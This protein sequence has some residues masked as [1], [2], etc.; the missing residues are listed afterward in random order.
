MTFPS[1]SRDDEGHVR[2][3][4]NGFKIFDYGK[5]EGVLVPG[6]DLLTKKHHIHEERP[7]V[8]DGLFHESV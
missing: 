2:M 7:I 6:G 5:I 1:R 4:C 3:K 8:M